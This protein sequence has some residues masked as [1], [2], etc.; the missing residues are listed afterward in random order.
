MKKD[1]IRWMFAIGLLGLLGF[2]SCSP[3]LRPRRAVDTA[4]TLKWT[5][6]DSIRVITNP[7]ERP[8]KLMYGVPPTRF[9]TMQAPEKELKTELK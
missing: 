6:P 4:D 8:I 5:L 1:R 2:T 7:G 3:R 9:E